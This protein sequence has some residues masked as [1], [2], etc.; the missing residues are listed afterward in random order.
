MLGRGESVEGD[1]DVVT[2]VLKCQNG[3]TVVCNYDQQSPRPYSHMLRIQGT[4]GLFMEDGNSIYV[5]GRTR[6]GAWEPSDKYQ[7]EFQHALWK[8]FGEEAKGTSHNG[9]DFF[10]DRAFV[11]SIQRGVQPPIDT[12]DTATWSAIIALSEQ[13][14][15]R[16]SAPVEFPDFT[17]GRWANN[18]R[19]FGLNDEY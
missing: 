2:T 7:A 1:R 3:E 17:D 14:H 19:I 16:G 15:D 13:S 11:E 8:K 18:Q 4:K 5:E 9:M 12:W 10:V 6:G